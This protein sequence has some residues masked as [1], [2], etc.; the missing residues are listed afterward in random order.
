MD[1]R[2]TKNDI[3]TELHDSLRH[4]KKSKTGEDCSTTFIPKNDAYDSMP[5]VTTER[6][7]Q[8]VETQIVEDNDKSNAKKQSLSSF[9]ST[10][11]SPCYPNYCGRLGKPVCFPQS[12]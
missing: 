5:V 1:T 12:Y 4:V 9:L 3:D 6:I 7:S 11:P 2:D 8:F 10:L